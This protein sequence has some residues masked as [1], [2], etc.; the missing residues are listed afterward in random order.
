MSLRSRP[1][2]PPLTRTERYENSFF[3][4][5]IKAWKELDEEAKTKTSVQSFKEYLQQFKQPNG[6]P[7]FGVCDKVGIKL[8][9]KIRVARSLI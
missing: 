5:T 8:L 1:D 6:H 3:P 4:F 9:A 2:N 7:L